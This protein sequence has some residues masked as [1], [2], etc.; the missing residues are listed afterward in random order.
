MTK[1]P[2]RVNPVLIAA[3]FLAVLFSLT[4]APVAATG[5]T[6]ET[7][8]LCT[9]LPFGLYPMITHPPV[10]ASLVPMV[11]M[12]PNTTVVTPVPI[13]TVSTLVPSQ[14]LVP[15]RVITTPVRFATLPQPPPPTTP[16]PTQ[17]IGL[18]RTTLGVVTTPQNVMTPSV[19]LKPSLTVAQGLCPA[20]KSWCN[21]ACKDL[22]TDNWNCGACQ[23]YCSERNWCDREGYPVTEVK[24]IGGKCVSDCGT[25]YVDLYH[26][27]SNCGCC[28]RQCGPG[29]F[30][31]NTSCAI[32][33]QGVAVIPDFD[34]E[35]CGSCGN[36]CPAELNQTCVHSTCVCKSGYVAC[37]GVCIPEDA[38][39]CGAC[40]HQCRTDQL[41]SSQGCI[42]KVGRE[43]NGVCSVL[44]N[45]RNNCGACGH[46]CSSR[47][48]ADCY[49]NACY[50]H[51]GGVSY[52]INLDTD[53]TNCG[54]CGIRCAAWEDCVRGQCKERTCPAGL[55]LCEDGLCYDTTSDN[56]N[57]GI[58]GR[59][60]DWNQYCIN[61]QCLDACSPGTADCY[62]NGE[63]VNLMTGGYEASHC[64]S[65]DH[66]CYYMTEVC[67]Q[68]NCLNNCPQ[69]YT[70]C[71]MGS[72]VNLNNDKNNCGTC[73]FKCAGTQKCE[74]G[75]C[76]LPCPDP[77]MKHCNGIC[78]DVMFSRENC[79]ACGST[80]GTVCLFG[81]CLW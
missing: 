39:N 31:Y 40:G 21:G 70:S 63:C 53:R 20:G 9:L 58:C 78:S 76:N 16:A 69:G 32:T 41:C 73:N 74:D 14:T 50:A 61:S 38:D 3:L 24:C 33:C 67:Y 72:C 54:Y 81:I 30:C 75:A 37:N 26:D 15:T 8:F 34:P 4:G 22:Q 64:G 43:C 5:E 7:T 12:V 13:K 19:Q 46:E 65:C 77:N 57:C 25:G 60:C 28:G 11:T 23:F 44:W 18:Q 51:C 10:G 80:C 79:G 55:A 45:D 66:N 59:R 52:D 2:S 62:H 56:K 1:K 49:S 36:R 42:C 71:N 17:T 35:N 48:S 27:S 29:Q 6:G 47:D 68:G